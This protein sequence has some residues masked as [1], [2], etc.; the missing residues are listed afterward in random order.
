MTCQF[1]IIKLSFEQKKKKERDDVTIEK[2]TL[3]VRIFLWSA[4]HKVWGCLSNSIWRLW[5]I[6]FLAFVTKKINIKNGWLI[7]VNLISGYA[8]SNFI[9]TKKKKKQTTIFNEYLMTLRW[10]HD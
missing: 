2:K 10:G 5:I 4:G 9:L 3:S 1:I 8:L 7:I 6:S